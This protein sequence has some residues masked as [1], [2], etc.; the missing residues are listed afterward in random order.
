[1]GEIAKEFLLRVLFRLKPI[2]PAPWWSGMTRV[3][4][5][6]AGSAFDNVV[7]Y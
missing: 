5:G 2:D 6:V 3:G 7:D 4:L 1:M